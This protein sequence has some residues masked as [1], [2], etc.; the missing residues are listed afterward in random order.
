MSHGQMTQEEV[1]HHV[2]TYMKVFG[3]LLVLTCLTVGVFYWGLSAHLPIVGAV[4]I[5]LIVASVK[6]SLVATFFMHLKSEHGMIF[7]ILVL[8]ALFFFV[9]LLIPV[10]TTSDNVGIRV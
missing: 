2:S 9:L 7:W 5:A 4:I 3:A 6:G 10:I 1:Q 8:C